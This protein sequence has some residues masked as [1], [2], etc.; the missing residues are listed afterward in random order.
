MPRGKKKT[1]A[2]RLEEMEM[3]R[4]ELSRKPPL[5]SLCLEGRRRHEFGR[6]IGK[7]HKECMWCGK[8]REQIKKE[9]TRRGLRS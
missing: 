3:E 6:G 9:Q 5:K 4:R 2:E 8:S 7:I 1:R